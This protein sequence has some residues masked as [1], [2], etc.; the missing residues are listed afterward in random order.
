MAGFTL[1][2]WT[3][4][5]TLALGNDKTNVEPSDMKP[6]TDYNFTGDIKNNS[7]SINNTTPSVH[8]NIYCDFKIR[9]LKIRTFNT[10]IN[11]SWITTSD[12]CQDILHNLDELSYSCDC[13]NSKYPGRK[14]AAEA[15]KKTKPDGGT[16]DNGGLEP[17]TDYR[18]KVRPI[19]NKEGPFKEEE[20]TIKTEPGIPDKPE[21]LKID[22]PENN[23]ILVKFSAKTF[24]GPE[25]KY[26]AELVGVPG[27]E[28]TQQNPEFEF[29]DL[30]YLTSYRI[31]V[32]TYN[33]KLESESVEIE[34]K[35]L[36]NDKALIG[37]LVVL[38]CAALLVAFFIRRRRQIRHAVNEEGL[39]AMTAIW[40]LVEE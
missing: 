27:S 1:L 31:K 16:C 19:Y 26:I 30:K 13:Q 22:Y 5:S 11:L 28:K 34:A 18:C 7:V 37:C 24:R 29:Q 21:V 15:K 38:T 25:T 23:K 6:F 39:L 14:V 4:S 40:G 2:I 36:Y 17:F 33:G 12:K 3:V 8:V 9:D 10:S 35:T 32:K 20:V